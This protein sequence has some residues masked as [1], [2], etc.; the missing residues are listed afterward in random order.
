MKHTQFI[1]LESMLFLFFL[2]GIK[3]ASG[4]T[5]PPDNAEWYYEV[6][7]MGT[8]N[9]PYVAYQHIKVEGDTVIN[10]QNSKIITRQNEQNLCGNMESLTEYIYE[11]N[12]RV[13]WYNTHTEAFTL[14]Y[15]FSAEEGD[16]W[17]ISVDACDFDVFVDSVDYVNI[18]GVQHKKLYISS[19]EPRYFSG[20][21]IEN[22][23]HTTSMF[24]KDIYW[25]CNGVA[26]DS[27]FLDGIRCYL[28]DNSMVYKPIDTACDSTWYITSVPHLEN[29]IIT[30]S[31]NPVDNQIQ[32]QL[33]DN[34]IQQINF[35]V[36]NILGNKLLEGKAKQNGT[37]N[38]SKL[39]T[40]VYI[41]L[42]ESNNQ[43]IYKQ[44]IMKK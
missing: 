38:T 12:D 19:D 21:I 26:C 10:S 8:T 39:N 36:Y 9:P 43:L 29:D 27:D 7:S 25:E 28:E 17:N 30:I 40:G 14:L 24:P 32:I 6:S 33:Q 1:L 11:E 23:G 31:P 16:S 3:S 34:M 20:S 15:D 18:N 5:W 42:L 35:S 2:I 44:K 13:Y 4:Q 37:I 22:I 41:L